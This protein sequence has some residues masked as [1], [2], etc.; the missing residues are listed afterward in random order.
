MPY[1]DADRLFDAEPKARGIARALYAGVKDLPLVSPHGHTDP[2]WYAENEKFPDPAQL[3]IVP[4]HY[5][6]RMLYSQGI[7]LEDLGVPTTDG[8]KVETDGRTIWRKFAENYYLFRGTPT[9]M[10][11]DHTF[12]TLF[13]L[14]EL[15]T[16]KNADRFYDP[17]SEKLQQDEFRPRALFERFNLEVIS[18]TDSAIDTLQWH[19]MIRESGW[20]GRV[21]PAYRPD[22]V[23]DPDF[24]GF[25]ANVDKLGE[26]TGRG[27]GQLARLS[28]RAPQAPR[29][30]QDLRRDV[31]RPWPP[32]RADV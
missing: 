10:W 11:L 9:R 14:D 15:L 16:A 25:P 8:R 20:K 7:R 3:L 24:P 23:V 1:L 30:L 19:K 32:H 2:R 28:R 18:T 4:D 6:F 26:I 21:I 5:V 22:A 29:I 27:Y 12:A 13:G 31:V 17:I